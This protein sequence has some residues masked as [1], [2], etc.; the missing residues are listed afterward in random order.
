MRIV[1]LDMARDGLRKLERHLDL[2]AEKHGIEEPPM[3]MP[4]V[5]LLGW[6][7]DEEDNDDCYD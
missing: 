4:S 2:V 1:K 3:L 6:E 5:D 7:D